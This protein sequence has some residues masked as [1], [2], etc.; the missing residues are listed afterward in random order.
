MWG[1]WLAQL[2]EHA[3][4]ELGLQSSSPTLHAEITFFKKVANAN[5]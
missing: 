4:L 1:T 2:L 3:T 5:L